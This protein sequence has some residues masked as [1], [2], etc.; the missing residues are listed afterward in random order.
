MIEHTARYGTRSDV[1]RAARDISEH[2][3]SRAE[4]GREYQHEYRAARARE[5]TVASA[6]RAAR[7][8]T[9]EAVHE[10]HDV[11]QDAL[12]GYGSRHFDKRAAR[13]HVQGLRRAALER[14]KG[15]AGAF[16]AAPSE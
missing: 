9:I 13:A 8:R 5:H 15:M 14:A 10:A 2:N 6:H 11:L 12:T 1:A 7:E 16:R 4:L 3:T